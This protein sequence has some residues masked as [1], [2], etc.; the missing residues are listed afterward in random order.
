MLQ[1]LAYTC[2]YLCPVAAP[3]FHNSS[4]KGRQKVY[5]DTQGLYR[6]TDVEFQI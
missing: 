5:E 3:A 1:W 6:N 2:M 4:G